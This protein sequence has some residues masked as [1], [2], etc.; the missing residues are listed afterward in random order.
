MT[1]VQHE[2]NGIYLSPL[3]AGIFA[4]IMTVSLVGGFGNIW[5]LNTKVIEFSNHIEYVSSPYTS[6]PGSLSRQEWLAE[7][8]ALTVELKAINEKLDALSKKL[9]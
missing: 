9:D 4:T 1:D 5:Y 7:R 2:R 3:W 8:R 6:L